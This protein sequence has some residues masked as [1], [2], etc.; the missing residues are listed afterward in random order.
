MINFIFIVGILCLVVL[1]FIILCID[2]PGV[3][4]LGELILL[5]IIAMFIATWSYATDSIEQPSQGTHY[6]TSK[7]TAVY[8]N[9][10]TKNIYYINTQDGNLWKSETLYKEGE[11][12]IFDTNNTEDVTDDKIIGIKEAK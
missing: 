2:E 1:C 3:A 4:I 12:L 8:E 5:C 6:R 10:A 11:I 9:S 7:V